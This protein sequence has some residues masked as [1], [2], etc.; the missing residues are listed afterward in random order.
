MVLETRAEPL[1]HRFD[2]PRGDATRDLRIDC[3]RIADHQVNGQR[4][5]RN[6]DPRKNHH[7]AAAATRLRFLGLILYIFKQTRPRRGAAP[8]QRAHDEK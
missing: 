2:L 5:H 1:H 4:E 3:A 6:R 8:Q 7:R